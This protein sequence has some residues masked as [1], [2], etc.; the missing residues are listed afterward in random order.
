MNDKDILISHAQDKKKQAYDNSMITNTNFLTMEERTWLAPSERELSSD[1]RTYY[2]G[3][4]ED[5]E[6]TIAVFV[7]AFYEIASDIDEYF[8]ENPRDNPLA[9]IKLTKDKFTSLSHRDYLGALMGLGIKREMLGDIITT[10]TGCYIFCLKSIVKYICENLNKSGRGTV[11]CKVCALKDLIIGEEKSETVFLS[12]AS[13]RLDNVVAAAFNLSR[14]VAV[15]AINK[16]IVYVNSLQVQKT[17]MSIK[18]GDRIVLRGKGKVLISELAGQ[19]KK[20]RLHIYIKK[21]K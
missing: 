5:A 3:G 15:E 16:G 11:T 1:I 20:G 12:V 8:D 6:R 9:L 7:P 18:Q 14:S 10:D 21:Y 2:Y 19:S 4:Y 13:M 17:D